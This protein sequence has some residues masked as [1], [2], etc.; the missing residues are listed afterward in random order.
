MWQLFNDSISVLIMIINDVKLFT[1]ETVKRT[2]KT[3]GETQNA[4]VDCEGIKW[5]CEHAIQLYS[6]YELSSSSLIYWDHQIRG[7]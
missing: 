6:H 2:K 4:Y 3:Q 1:R 5:K 7:S